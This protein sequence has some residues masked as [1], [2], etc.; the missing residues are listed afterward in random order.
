MAYKVTDAATA[1]SVVESFAVTINNLTPTLTFADA[2][3][4]TGDVTITVIR[5]DAAMGIFIQ[6]TAGNYH[7]C[8]L[9]FDGN[10]YC[11]G[12]DNDGQLGDASGIAD[13]QTAVLVDTAAF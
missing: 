8:G 9:A 12:R 3:N 10:S 1:N 5:I 7:T 13:Q 11:W 4:I 2:A 6:L